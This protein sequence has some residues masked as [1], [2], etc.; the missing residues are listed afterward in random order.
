MGLKESGLRGS[1]RNV[2]VGIDA[3]PDT[4]VEQFD[5][6]SAF[7]TSD[8][9]T[10]VDS[11]EGET[12][13]YTVTGGS[14]TVIGDGINGQRMLS[15]DG[16]DDELGLPSSEFSTIS[17][18]YVII[19]VVRFD[20]TGEEDR[21]FAA[22]DFENDNDVFIGNR[23]D[24]DNWQIEAGAALEGSG[25]TGDFLLTADFNSS[26]SDLRFNGSSDVTGDAGSLS[27]ESI[28]FGNRSGFF[29]TVDIGFV[30][31]HDGEPSD[32]L[33]SRESEI[34]DDWGLSS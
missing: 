15:F 34:M 26:N 6:R 13:T 10:T 28:N 4:V 8:E 9:G 1:L 31:I 33:P 21:I 5:A 19:M 7:G 18:R 24:N 2:S 11:W 29:A 14:P 23:G 3:I 17:Q 30:E 20:N 12:G 27:L 22:E 25:Q 16:T 32:G